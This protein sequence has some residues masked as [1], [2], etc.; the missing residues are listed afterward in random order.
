MAFCLEHAR[1][2][3]S[4]VQIGLAGKNV[5]LPFDEVCYRELT[6]TSG[7]ASTPG[8]WTTALGLIETRAVELEQLVSEVVP[9]SEW[10]RAFAAT[11]AGDGV[12]FVLDP[13]NEGEASLAPT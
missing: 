5:T 12:K 6:V 4:Y 7:K 13:R 1:G 3:G 10:E 11:R 2:G 9:L 8:S